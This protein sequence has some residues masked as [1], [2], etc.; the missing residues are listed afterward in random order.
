MPIR[1]CLATGNKQESSE[2]WRFTVQEGML[3]FDTPK[4][5]FPGR[6]G[7]IEKTDKALKRLPSLGKKIKHFLKCDSVQIPEEEILHKMKILNN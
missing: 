2:L 7:Y 1:T 6:G 5:Q 3:K 4:N